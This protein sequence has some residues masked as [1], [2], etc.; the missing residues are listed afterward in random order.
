M[1]ELL[2]V[3]LVLVACSVVYKQV[4]RLQNNNS[5]TNSNNKQA[6]EVIARETIHDEL[7]RAIAKNIGFY[8]I[9][10]DMTE[11]TNTQTVMLIMSWCD[12]PSILHNG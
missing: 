4:C 9:M 6:A 5:Q 10:H 12:C 3:S 2:P 11:M 1:V 7:T 8:T